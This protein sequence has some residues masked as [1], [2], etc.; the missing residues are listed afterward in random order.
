VSYQEVTRV[1]MVDNGVAVLSFIVET[2]GRAWKVYARHYPVGLGGPTADSNVWWFMDS[3][4]A[5]AA[6]AEKVEEARAAG[7]LEQKRITE[8]ESE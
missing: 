6:V 3:R 1:D 7:W 2:N 8:E 4:R 5:E